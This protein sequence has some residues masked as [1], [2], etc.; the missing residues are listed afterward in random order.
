MQQVL[1]WVTLCAGIILAP[2]VNDAHSQTTL[3]TVGLHFA[4]QGHEQDDHGS[5]VKPHHIHKEV[6]LLFHVFFEGKGMLQLLNGGTAAL[7]DL[8][9]E[10][11]LTQATILGTSKG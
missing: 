1:R 10:H 3:L 8:A 7:R 11:G 2:G 5:N 4:S 9:I 6:F